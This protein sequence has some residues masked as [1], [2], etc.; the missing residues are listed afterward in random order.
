M[1][2]DIGILFEGV[3]S[4]V[5]YVFAGECVKPLECECT[6]SV[7]LADGSTAVEMK[8]PG[9]SWQNQCNQW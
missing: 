5:A 7:T 1:S 2:E 8:E 3:C 9:E 6:V 4:M